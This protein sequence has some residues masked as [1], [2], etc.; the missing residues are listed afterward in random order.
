MQMDGWT[1]RQHKANTHFHKFAI[2]L[3][4]EKIKVKEEGRGERKRRK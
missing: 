3:K 4:M 1:D 2:C